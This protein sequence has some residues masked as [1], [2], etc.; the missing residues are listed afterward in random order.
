M[1][2]RNGSDA[3]AAY[4]MPASVD[5]DVQRGMLAFGRRSPSSSNRLLAVV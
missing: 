1:E 3:G 2:M 5:G 4:S